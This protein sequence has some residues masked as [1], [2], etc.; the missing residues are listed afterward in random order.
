V[1]HRVLRTR[2][3]AFAPDHG[4][5]SGLNSEAATCTNERIS[6]LELPRF[7]ATTSSL[8]DRSTTGTLTSPAGSA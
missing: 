6:G 1:G 3:D 7:Q 8:V 5:P 2:T 4:R